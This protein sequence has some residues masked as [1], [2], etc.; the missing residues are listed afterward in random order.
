MAWLKPWGELTKLILEFQLF[1]FLG[2]SSGEQRFVKALY[3]GYCIC[4]HLISITFANENNLEKSQERY[5]YVSAFNFLR[6]LSAFFSLFNKC[7][8]Y[9]LSVHALGLGQTF[10]SF[11]PTFLKKKCTAC[12]HPADQFRCGSKSVFWI[13]ALSYHGYSI[14]MDGDS[15]KS[16]SFSKTN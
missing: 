10:F 5:L 16:S 15:T 2:S 8:K 6:T 4:K 3:Q 7:C 14:W 11:Y 9:R 1:G 12:I 13:I